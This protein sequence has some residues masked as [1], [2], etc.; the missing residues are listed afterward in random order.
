MSSCAECELCVQL[1]GV[2]VITDNGVV[3]VVYACL[4]FC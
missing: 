4:K 3:T 2:C 1:C